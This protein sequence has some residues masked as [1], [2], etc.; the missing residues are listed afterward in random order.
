MQIHNS[1]YALSL[2]LAATLMNVGC[3]KQGVVTKDEGVSTTQIE[4]QA[5]APKVKQQNQNEKQSKQTATPVVTEIVP[6]PDTAR[7]VPRSSNEQLLSDLTT[8][9][10]T[11]DS[12]GLSESARSSLSNNAEL[13]AKGSVD[14]IRIEGNCDERGSAEYNLALG[15]RR[16]K[17]VHQYL[18]T[19]GVDPDRLS[20]ISYGK[21]KTAV[22]G[23]NEEAWAKNR[24][25]EFVAVTQ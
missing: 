5:E 14:K 18:E 2:F 1:F 3:A 4:R 25:A 10:F 15:E 11:F 12:S 8:I 20:I 24:R 6:L 9:Y 17:S 23:S 19:L 16:A 7:L 22:L 13:L 21:E